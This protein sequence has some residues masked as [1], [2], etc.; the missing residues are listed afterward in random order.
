LSIRKSSSSIFT[1]Q[2]HHID[3]DDLQPGDKVSVNQIESSAPGLVAISCGKP[4]NATYHAASVYVDHASRC[5]FIK[6]YY[7]T[8]GSEAVEGKRHFEQLALSHGVKIKSYRT[9]NGI[10]ACKEYRYEV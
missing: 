2:H 7:S 1:I 8:G 4:T 9:D 10:M 3:H 5:T 6:M